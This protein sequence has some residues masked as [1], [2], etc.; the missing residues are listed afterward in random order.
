[1]W[2]GVPINAMILKFHAIDESSGWILLALLDSV[3]RPQ[4]PQYPQMYNGKLEGNP[5]C[6]CQP[7]EPQFPGL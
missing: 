3:F 2:V 7:S 1:V 6:P 4:G 5:K